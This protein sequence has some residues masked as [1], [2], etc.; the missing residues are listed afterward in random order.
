MELGLQFEEITWFE[1]TGP[2]AVT[3]EESLET[4]IPEYCSD[5]A[6][7]VDASG[8]VCLREKKLSE[9]HL[10][11]SGAVKVR[12]LYTSEESAGLR[13]MTLSVP[14]ACRMEDQRLSE[15]KASC[16]HTRLLLCEVKA[17]TSRKVYVRVMPE[18]SVSGYLPQKCRLCTRANEGV[19][20]RRENWEAVLLRHVAEREFSLTQEVLMDSTHP[21][22]DELLSDR[23][24]L[25]VDECQQIGSKL[26]VKGRAEMSVLYRAEGQKLCTFE[27]TLPF[28]RILD[29]MEQPEDTV[30]AAYPQLLDSE[31]RLLRTENGSGFGVTAGIGLVI[32]VQERHSVSYIDDL[33]CTDCESRV[34]RVT[35]RPTTA[36]Q[37]ECVR[38]ELTEK[39]EFGRGTP[40]CYPTQV[41]CGQV[42]IGSEENHTALRSNVRM[43]VLYLDEGGS[44]MCSERTAEVSAVVAD[45]PD[46][47]QASN[48]MPTCR[49]SSGSCVVQIPVTFSTCICRK[50]ELNLITDGEILEKTEVEPM[51]SVVM[52]RME[53][54]ENLWDIAKQYRTDM[55]L[56]RTAND[57]AEGEIPE[58][59]LLIP[60]LR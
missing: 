54:G 5:V 57:L 22:P 31:L 43:K 13:G 46:H 32:C 48:E 40:F 1:E 11:V 16:I 49:T 26:V 19:Q 9:G 38:Q 10:T 28:S 35:L 53:Q 2:I 30:F 37:R 15:C 21:M 18:L 20:L 4:A 34:E 33:Y 44:P 42:S 47:C 59:M 25:H 60:K 7:I 52:R 51:P 8:Q 58:K 29:G 6:R 27:A 17:L 45:P 24:C 56:I 55:D 50:E 12:V 3:Q 39:L 14:F 36:Y 41:D 23:I